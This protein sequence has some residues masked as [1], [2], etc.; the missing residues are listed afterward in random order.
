MVS[1]LLTPPLGSVPSLMQPCFNAFVWQMHKFPKRQLS[2]LIQRQWTWTAVAGFNSM[3]DLSWIESSW[4]AWARASP[5]LI[6]AGTW[7]GCRNEDVL[8]LLHNS[9][10][11]EKRRLSNWYLGQNTATLCMCAAL[12]WASWYFSSVTWR[13]VPY[14]ALGVIKQIRDV[15]CCLEAVTPRKRDSGWSL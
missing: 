7:F 1:Y 15:C 13:L 8:L 3:L 10:L 5:Y 12:A 6:P 4:I 14:A 2:T 11:N 9:P